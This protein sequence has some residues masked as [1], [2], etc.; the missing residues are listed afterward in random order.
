MVRQQGTSL[1]E[2]LVALGILG[3]IGA[4]FLTA[5]S[6]G[7]SGAGTVDEHFTAENLVRTQI[8]DI[9]SLPYDDSNYYPVTVSP[10]P[11][12][13]VLID[14]TD[15]SPPEYPNTLQ[16]LVVSV[17]REGQAVLAVESYK[18]KL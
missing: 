10:P 4:V 17:F 11:E 7:L 6:S 13:E 3:I 16:K 1:L 8:E 12:Y 9:K 2:V 18:A 5:I 15:V 14:V